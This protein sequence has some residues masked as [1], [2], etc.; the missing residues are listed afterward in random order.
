MGGTEVWKLELRWSSVL[1]LAGAA[2]CGCG[3][4]EEDVPNAVNDRSGVERADGGGIGPCADGNRRECSIILGEHNG[5]VTCY[6]GVQIC[7]DGN[8]GDCEGGRVEEL[9]GVVD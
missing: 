9:P 1:L 2:L 6:H 4:A 3:P 8:W 5:I 7:Q